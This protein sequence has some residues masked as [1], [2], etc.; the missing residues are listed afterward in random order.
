M[1][2]GSATDFLWIRG[3]KL[4]RISQRS[5]L[6]IYFCVKIN[7]SANLKDGILLWGFADVRIFPNYGK[8]REVDLFTFGLGY[9]ESI[10]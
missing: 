7:G 9:D 8:L 2:F 1:R 3:F 5:I 10:T 6:L 4:A